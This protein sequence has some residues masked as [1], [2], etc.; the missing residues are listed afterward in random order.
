MRAA[1]KPSTST[2]RIHRGCPSLRLAFP[3]NDGRRNQSHP[4]ESRKQVLHPKAAYARARQSACLPEGILR[5]LIFITS[6]KRRLSVGRGPDPSILADA[7]AL[8]PS[9]ETCREYE[10][11]V[12]AKYLD[13]IRPATKQFSNK[14][15]SR[16]SGVARSAIMNF[17]KGRT[18]IKPRTLRKL[19]TAVHVYKTTIQKSCD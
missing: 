6:A 12:D 8:D 11:L 16:R 17:K 14:L 9:D 13:H 18:T 1:A 15:L 3:P 4:V 7:G 2:T 10:R 19:T 5:P